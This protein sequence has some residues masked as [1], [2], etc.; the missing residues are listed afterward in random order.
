MAEPETAAA[1]PELLPVEVKPETLLE[2]LWQCYRRETPSHTWGVVGF[3]AFGEKLL[4]RTKIASVHSMTGEVTLQLGGSVE[5]LFCR[6]QQPAPRAFGGP[7][8]GSYKVTQAH[9]AS[10]RSYAGLPPGVKKV[11]G[12]QDD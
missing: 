1:H 10:G 9:E 4:S 3:I 11:T 2:W 6:L 7:A 12:N 5:V 8:G